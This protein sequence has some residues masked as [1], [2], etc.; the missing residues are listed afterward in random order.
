[1]QQIFDVPQRQRKPDVHHH[2]QADDL[3]AALKA[4]EALADR[5]VSRDRSEQ[6][7]AYEEIAE[8]GMEPLE[9]MAE[10]YRS[11][12]DSVTDHDKKAQELERRRREVK[13][14][15]DALVKARPVDAEVI[16]G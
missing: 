11:W 1:M 6:A 13:R 7:G 10:V 3:R 8:L 15:Y 12:E 5:A 9:L 14:D 4:F 16:E 2:R